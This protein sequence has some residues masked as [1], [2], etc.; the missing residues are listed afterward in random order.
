MKDELKIE[1]WGTLVD[2]FGC[3][4]QLQIYLKVHQS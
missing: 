2:L 1:K 3:Q 4:I